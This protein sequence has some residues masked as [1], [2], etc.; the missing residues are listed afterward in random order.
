MQ[1]RVRTRAIGSGSALLLGWT[2]MMHR[3][4]LGAIGVLFGLLAPSAEGLATPVAD[5]RQ[6][7][8]CLALNIYFEARSEPRAG[9]LAVGHVVM[10][11]VA[12]KRYPSKICDV[13]K[14]GGEARRHKCQFSW[15]C[16]G[17]SDNPRNLRAWQQSLV[18]ARV[19]FWGYSE[20][21]TNG[22]LWYHAD[23][24][25]PYWRKLLERGPK[26]GRH[27]FYVADNASTRSRLKREDTQ[28]PER[29]P[30]PVRNT[31]TGEAAVQPVAVRLNAEAT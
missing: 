18:L 1:G 28:A 4:T 13:V 26:I 24:A 2:T 15:F 9:K 29:M 10:N 30:P 6:E 12:D 27:L 11:R 3:G 19:I 23:Y 20:D 14:Q 25:R 16:D 31:A 5:V 22:A 17:L 21:P 8:H 7:I